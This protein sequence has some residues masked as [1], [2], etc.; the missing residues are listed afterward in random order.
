MTKKVIITGGAG[1]VGHHLVNKIINSTDYEVIIIDKLSYASFGYDRLRENAI[2]QQNERVKVFTADLCHKIPDGLAKEIGENVE[3]IFHLAAESHVDKSIE[4]PFSFIQANIIGTHYIL[5][6]ARKLPKLKNFVYFSTDEVFGPADK[7]T[8][9]KEWDRYNSTNPYSATKAGAE[10]LCLAYANTFQI[11]LLITHTMNLFGERQHPEKYI[12]KVIKS[13]LDQK[14]VTIHADE[15][16][17]IPGSRFYMHCDDL[18]DAILYLIS[19]KQWQRD[20]VNIVGEV[21]IDN[22][23]LAQ[24]IAGFIG[25]PLNYELVDYHSSRPGHDLRYSLDG[26][27]LKELGWQTTDGFQKKLEQTVSW[28]LKNREWLL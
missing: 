6:F 12:P 21:E 22:L 13:V 28:Y 1:F 16:L 11:P 17:K 20:K 25:K 15:S 4:D 8:N 7:S 18:A 14:T 3:Y 10:E 23:E 24:T 26:S 19:L 27:K 2:I 9:Y 5:E